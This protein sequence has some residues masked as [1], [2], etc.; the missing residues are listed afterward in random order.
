MRNH[1][2]KAKDMAESVLPSKARHRSRKE[3]RTIHESERARAKQAISRYLARPDLGDE[4]IDAHVG[5]GISK[6]DMAE[7]VWERRS[8]DK[9]GSLVRWALRR[10]E[11]D[12]RLSNACVAEQVEYFRRLM[13][14]NLIGRHAVSHIETVLVARDWE[15]RY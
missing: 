15:S 6:S 9:I 12:S 4:I 8:A 1:N 3:R 10:V 5:R 7:M 2:E 11:T 14:D 13:P